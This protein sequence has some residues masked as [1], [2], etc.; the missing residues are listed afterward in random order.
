M[1]SLE[2]DTVIY[3]SSSNVPTMQD[4]SKLEI[5]LSTPLTLSEA[6]NFEVAVVKIQYPSNYN[7]VT[8]GHINYYS[9][10]LKKRIYT[11]IADGY[12]PDADSFMKAFQKVLGND[13]KHYQLTYIPNTKLFL[14]QLQGSDKCSI[15]LS[16]NL[17][18]LCGLPQKINGEGFHK[19][20]SAW[21]GTGGNSTLN[22]LCNIVSL[23]YINDTK[24]PLILSMS[25][26]AGQ[27]AKVRSS[28]NLRTP[29]IYQFMR[30]KLSR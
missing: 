16:E 18:R 17:S 23:V 25:Y 28:M 5:A 3:V 1:A 22:V 11:R 15:Q 19:A 13:S 20:D 6:I 21:D 4:K 10:T 29:F 2:E 27:K 8:E 24:K 26:G 7:N 30:D 9:L 14:I 12:Y